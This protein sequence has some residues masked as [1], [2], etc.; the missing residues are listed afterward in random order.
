MSG[1][2]GTLNTA[3][4]GLRA[5]QLVLQTTSHNV[6]NAGTTGYSRQ[7]VH[8]AP[9][10]PELLPCG[11]VGTG[12]SVADIQRIRD[13]FLDLQ[14]Y[15][16]QERLG[17]SQAEMDIV[18][19]LQAMFNEPS[20]AGLQESLSTFFAALRQLGN[21]PD[22]L[23][24]RRAVLEQGRNVAEDFQR[25]ARSLADLKRNVE[26]EIAGRVD[27][28][29]G[30]VETVA[31]L[32]QQI[33]SQV[34]A[35]VA[36]N[37]L[38]DQRDLALDRLAALVGISVTARADGS[39]LVALTGG[40]GVLVDG[41][42]AT[43]LAMTPDSS[44]DA[45][46][47]SRD[48]NPLD[49][50]GGELA[51]LLTAR[52]AADGALKTAERLLDSLAQG[53]AAGLNRLQVT[54]A[55]LVAPTE[56]AGTRAVADPTQPL[57]A[58]LGDSLTVP[59]TI[60]IFTVDQ[61]TGRATSSQTIDVTAGTTLT[62]LVDALNGLQGIRARLEGGAIRLEAE[63]G[64]GIRVAEDSAQVLTALGMGGFFIGQT[65]A[66][67][68]LNPAL[69]ANPLLLATALPDPETGE[70]G[71]ADNRVALRMAA[72]QSAKILDGGT[73]APLEA[74]AAG[75]GALGSRAVAVQRAVESHTLIRQSVERQRQEVSGVSLDEEM[76][77]LLQAQRAFQASAR[78]IA[79]M[80]ELL[81][82]V[83]NG[84]LR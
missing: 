8:L 31:R 60:R 62:D 11:Q 69:L 74:Y 2:T 45:V 15:A 4:S 21:Y 23:T 72:L 24:T 6:A 49:P 84:L 17:E 52:N 83:V 57:A 32:S 44:A 66:T 26:T 67:L 12:V 61:S 73:S 56:L 79:L 77:T 78:V 55:G 47:L 75:I 9:S 33:Q 36:A 40:R 5:A 42:R 80:D 76:V 3:L 29:N 27:E 18:M 25:L 59:G 13:R 35:G 65:A 50:Q 20:E 37:T 1:I 53:L 46:Q 51:A 68:A 38:A 22:D 41:N 71:S 48:G 10:P 28:V 16:A 64:R 43:A 39:L 34:L 81:D 19:Q 54:G 14:Y 82:T 70:V 7:Q 58:V 30:L 63:N